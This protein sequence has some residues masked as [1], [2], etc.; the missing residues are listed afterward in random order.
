[1]KETSVAAVMTRP[2]CTIHAN[3]RLDK[4]LFLFQKNRISILPV[5]NTSGCCVGVITLKDI[6]D[7]QNEIIAEC[8]IRGCIVDENQLQPLPEVPLNF[9]GEISVHDGMT[10][11][12]YLIREDQTVSECIDLL[13]QHQIHHLP[14]VNLDNRLVGV[15]S[16]IDLVD[17]L[18]LYMLESEQQD[19]VTA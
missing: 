15:V 1:M 19:N 14:V 13:L 16:S 6:I 10:E 3:E 18:R 5:V 17:Y 12:F 7:K 8:R 2:V 11:N 4:A 9:F